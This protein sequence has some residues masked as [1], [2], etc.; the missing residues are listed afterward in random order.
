MKIK[1]TEA[2]LSGMIQKA[3]NKVLTEN[4]KSGPIKEPK[5]PTIIKTTLA[6]VRQLITQIIKEESERKFFDNFEGDAENNFEQPFNENDPQINEM[7]KESSNDNIKEIL[8]NILTVIDGEYKMQGMLGNKGVFVNT[9][10]GNLR[11]RIVNNSIY[12][13]CENDA[14]GEAL[15]SSINNA[16]GDVISAGI[17]SSGYDRSIVIITL[18]QDSFDGKI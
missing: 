17:P 13:I 15:M 4:T 1:I 6:E 14:E 7:L 16:L 9:D 8:D 5:K 12:V 10:F 2:A 3:V 11:F 18:V